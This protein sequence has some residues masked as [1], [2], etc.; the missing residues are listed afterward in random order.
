MLSKAGQESCLSTDE[1]FSARLFPHGDKSLSTFAARPGI[2]VVKTYHNSSVVG[3]PYKSSR[4]RAG[5]SFTLPQPLPLLNA[6]G[7]LEVFATPPLGSVASTSFTPPQGSVADFTALAEPPAGGGFCA[8]NF[9]LCVVLES[10]SAAVES[11]A[12]GSAP[13]TDLDRSARPGDRIAPRV[14]SSSA[15][16]WR[17]HGWQSAL[18]QALPWL[19]NGRGNISVAKQLR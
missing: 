5:P 8:R 7:C 17:R 12:T 6:S 11:A 19:P 1:D 10:P 9:F 2:V 15:Y 14:Y 18:S 4:L 13:P 3:G 16:R